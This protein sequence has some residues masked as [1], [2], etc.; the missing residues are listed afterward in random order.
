MTM[1]R[2]GITLM[3]EGRDEMAADIGRTFL[4]GFPNMNFTFDPSVIPFIQMLVAGGDLDEARKHT[5]TLAEVTREYMIFFDSLDERDLNA[6][7]RR[8]FNHYRQGINQMSSLLEDIGDED[9]EA[10]ILALIDDFR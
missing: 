6:G 1:M 2:T 4:N 8:D 5:R 3:E 10:E 9:F 7:W